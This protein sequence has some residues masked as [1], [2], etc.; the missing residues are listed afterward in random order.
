MADSD[1]DDAPPTHTGW[2]PEEEAEV[3]AFHSLFSCKVSCKLSPQQLKIIVQI[4]M[5]VVMIILL[6][7]FGNM[8]MPTNLP[9]LL[10]PV[11]TKDLCHLAFIKMFQRIT[12][13]LGPINIVIIVGLQVQLI[14]FL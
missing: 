7:E 1:H 8:I 10:V 4:V 5:L 12:G 2:T 11:G 14:M 3:A 9:I 13:L 6:R